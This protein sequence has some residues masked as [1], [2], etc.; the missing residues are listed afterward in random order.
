MEN[1]K[2]YKV[3]VSGA[4]G[5]VGSA[6][7]SE[8]I[9]DSAEVTAIGRT[10]PRDARMD[11]IKWD[12]SNSNPPPLDGYDVIV[13][14]AAES[15]FGFWTK[16][17][18]EKILKSRV[19]YTKKLAEAAANSKLPPKVF[20]CASAVGYYGNRACGDESL[21]KGSGFLSDVCAAWEAS[22]KC[23][24]SAGIRTVNL[25]FGIVIN[26]SGGMVG[27]LSPYYR[28]GFGVIFG[29]GEN[30]VSWVSLADAAGA[31]LFC[32]KNSNISGPV[33][34]ACSL[35][36]SL[37]S[38][39]RLRIPAFLVRLFGGEVAESL[40]L[41]DQNIF[42]SKLL[43]NGFKFKYPEISEALAAK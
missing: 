13:H 19:D 16:S 43:K 4:G 20:I 11:F 27:K 34:F 32:A 14:L 30:M 39:V 23:A 22:T 24:E 15:V 38:K 37:G 28:K 12:S 21:P 29:N 33:K 31:A 2:S 18:R 42:P 6:V 41:A 25:R 1:G 36:Q 26:S 17:K 40:I 5:F 3:L 8:F 10:P 7:C 35:A 9:A